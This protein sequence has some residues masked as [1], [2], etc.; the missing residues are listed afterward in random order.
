MIQSLCF[1]YIGHPIYCENFITALSVMKNKLFSIVLLFDC[2]SGSQFMFLV[3]QMQNRER[4]RGVRRMWKGGGRRGG[5]RRGT[6]GK[7]KRKDIP[8]YPPSSRLP[9]SLLSFIYLLLLRFIIVVVETECS[10]ET[11]LTLNSQSFTN[12][13]WN[14]GPLHKPP[15]PG[16]PKAVFN[17]NNNNKS[18]LI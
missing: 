3:K 12:L 18:S 10:C 14:Q 6:K 5:H 8:V 2:L 15:H 4:R 13:R 17:N 9:L 16:S 7:Q 11:S 1:Q